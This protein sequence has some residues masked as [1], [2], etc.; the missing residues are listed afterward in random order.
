[1]Q[2]ALTMGDRIHSY[3]HRLVLSASVYITLLGLIDEITFPCTGCE[4]VNFKS[5]NKFTEFKRMDGLGHRTS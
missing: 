4:E 1:M 5:Q 3:D 2:K